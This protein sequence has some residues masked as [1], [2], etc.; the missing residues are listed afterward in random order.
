MNA[1][2]VEDVEFKSDMTEAVAGEIIVDARGESIVMRD[3]MPI[4]VTFFAEDQFMGFSGCMYVSTRVMYV[5][6]KAREDLHHPG[7]PNQQ[8]SGL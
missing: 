8:C 4:A 5:Y 3:T 6:I 1:P 7:R 2:R